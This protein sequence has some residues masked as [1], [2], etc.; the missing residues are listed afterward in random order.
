MP[1][2]LSLS[3]IFTNWLISLNDLWDFIN[4]PLSYSLEPLMIAFPPFAVVNGVLSIFGAYNL[5]L[6]EFIFVFGLSTIL[7]LKLV[8]FILSFIP[9]LYG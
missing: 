1:N 2:L 7:A 4:T 6:L 8:K 9:F 5:T 3:S